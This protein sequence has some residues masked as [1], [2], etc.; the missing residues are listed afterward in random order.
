MPYIVRPGKTPNAATISTSILCLPLYY[1]LEN[2][3]ITRVIEGVV[4]LCNEFRS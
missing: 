2:E 1:G 3:K 4:R